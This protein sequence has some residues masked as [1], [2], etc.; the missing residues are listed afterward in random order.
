MR[1]RPGAFLAWA[2]V[3][4]MAAPSLLAQ[5]RVR[6]EGR[7]TDA[8]TGAPL[9]H[10]VVAIE[11]TLRLSETGPD[12]RYRLDSLPPG[13][14]TV[15][16]VL[17]GYAPLRRAVTLPTEGVVTLDLTLAAS[18]LQLPGIIV[19]ADPVGRA[20]GELTTASVIEREAI[21]VQAAASLAGLLELIPGVTLSPPGLDGVQQISLRSVP[22]SSGGST[23]GVTAGQPSAGALAAFGTQIVLDGVPVSNNANFQSLGPRGELG[24][25]NSAGG[26]VD[27]RRFPAATIERVEVIRGIP[28][29]RYGDLTQ[30]AVIVDTRAGSVAPEVIAR[31]DYRTIE[32]SAVGGGPVGGSHL[33]SGT[34]NLA[35]TLISPGLSSAT[36]TRVALQ[37]AHHAQ[38][39][40]WTLNSRVD[41]VQTVEDNPEREVFPGFA[42]KSRDRSLRLSERAR[43]NLGDRSRLEITAGF[44]IG[45][46]SSFSQAPKLRG[47]MPFTDAITEGRHVG[48]F[49]GGT[50]S[51]RVDVD[52]APRHLYLR[53][54]LSSDRDWLGGRHALRAGVELRREWNNGPGVQFDIEFPPQ[55]RFNGVNGFD[56]PRNLTSVPPL[57]MSAIYLDDL[58]TWTL[59]GQGYVSIQGGLRFDALH[60]GGSTTTLRDRVLQPRV[61]VEVGPR[62][63]VRA[64]LGAGRLAKTPSLNGLNPAPQYYDL[65]NVNY[66]PNDPAERLAVITTRILDPTNPDLGFMVAEHLEAGL[67]LDLPSSDFSLGLAAFVERTPKAIGF[68]TQPLFLIRDRFALADSTQGTGHPP[69]ILEPP[70]AMDTIPVLLDRPA[71]NLSVRSRGLEL[72]AAIPEIPHTRT[73]MLVNGSW[74]RSEVDNASILFNSE[75]SNFQLAEHIPRAPYWNGSTRTGERLLVTSR[76]IHQQPKIGIVVMATIQVTLRETRRDIAATDTL[77]FAGYITRAGV[78]V[79]VPVEQRGDAQFADLHVGLKGQRTDEQRAPRDWLLNLQVSKTL[80]LGG[81]FAFYAF[82]L[83]DK[84]GNYG[85]AFTRARLFPPMRVGVEITMPV[86]LWQ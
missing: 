19:T 58:A 40:G 30:G 66:F 22:T 44:D 54:E 83:L 73:R 45:R 85:D 16:V 25:S 42:S 79:P 1:S 39:G 78:L 84:V 41:G 4:S 3:S 47:A 65:V 55:D 18:A 17:I 64:R 6:L 52:G 70:F 82:N 24:F 86:P 33:L 81:R 26:G 27:L 10:A 50:Y 76:L 69:D 35:R 12:G 56:R 62:P 49:I 59:G 7:V 51:A 72:T 14:Q 74:S 13:P 11:G 63:W 43:L 67:D 37:A 71:H 36:G 28:S 57:L 20:R 80:P 53:P 38:W 5:D 75:F 48:K 8:T 32:V 15:R 21:K 9:A 46:Q 23:T 29:V 77:S 61:T 60:E 34:L 31:L 68:L 2:L